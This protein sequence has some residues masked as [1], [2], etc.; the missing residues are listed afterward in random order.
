MTARLDPYKAAPKAVAAMMGLETYVSNCSLEHSLKELVKT[1]ASQ[2]NACAFCLHMHTEDARKAGEREERLY[3][4]SAWR[5]S[6]LFSLREKA[7]LGWTEALTS[8]AQAHPSEEAYET[9]RLH[10]NEEEIVQLTLLIGTINVWNRLNVAFGYSHPS[11]VG[12]LD[13]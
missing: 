7:A 12:L 13:A 9:V 11:E 1:R 2:I 10:F 8:L 6:R 4:L 3:L 5:E